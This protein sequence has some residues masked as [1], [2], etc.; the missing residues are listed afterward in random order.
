MAGVGQ[1]LFQPEGVLTREQ[2]SAM[3]YRY[4]GSPAVGS[5]EMSFTDAASISD[6]AQTAMEWAVS[7]GVLSGK[8][9]GILDPLGQA[10]RAEVAQ[11]LMNFAQSK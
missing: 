9:N 1:N 7:Q 6:W 11:M 5:V 3:L 8:G 4:Q 2:L 10:T